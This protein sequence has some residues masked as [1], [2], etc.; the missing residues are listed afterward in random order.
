MGMF[1]EA[2]RVAASSLSVG[3]GVQAS[4]RVDGP[5][6]DFSVITCKLQLPADASAAAAKST[7]LVGLFVRALNGSSLTISVRSQETIL[8]LAQ[9][10][11]VRTGVPEHLF[12][13]VQQSKV[14]SGAWT[15]ARAG[16]A[17]DSHVHMCV[18]LRGGAG[19]GRV[20][21]EGEW[22]CHHVAWLGAGPRNA[23]AFDV[24][25]RAMRG[26]G[27]R[28]EENHCLF[29]GNKTHWDGPRPTPSTGDPTHRVPRRGAPQNKG[30]PPSVP[31]VTLDGKGG[32]MSLLNAFLQTLG[33]PQEVMSQVESKLAPPRPKGDL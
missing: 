19:G 14:L 5:S 6:G 7:D 4:G 2:G 33:L 32:D 13:L 31:V 29:R 26:M 21:I 18:R 30:T 8:D 12:C 23:S 1:W 9:R 3:N 20:H 27:V 17:S 16:V 15:L 24:V 28:W 22:N 25:I 11:S 10:L